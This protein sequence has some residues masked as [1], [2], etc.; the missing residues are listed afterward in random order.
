MSDV[1]DNLCEGKPQ[2][3]LIFKETNIKQE[4]MKFAWYP[5]MPTCTGLPF[6]ELAIVFVRQATTAWSSW[7]KGNKVHIKTSQNENHINKKV[8]IKINNEHLPW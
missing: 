4:T 7:V 8:K 1:Q 6:R 3:K 2:S 5:I